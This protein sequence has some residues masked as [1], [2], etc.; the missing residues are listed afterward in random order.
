[1]D[2]VVVI[3]NPVASQFTG[4]A[5]RDVMAIFDKA[6]QVH[7]LWPGSGPEAEQAAAEAVADG[8]NIVVAMGGDGIVHHVAQ[9]VVGSE[10]V[11]GVIPVGTTNVFARILG[12]PTRPAKAAKLIARGNPPR[13]VGVARMVLSRGTVET[14]H[15]AL[16]SCGLG[17]DAEIVVSADA[18]PYRKYRFGSLHYASTALSVALRRFPRRRPHIEAVSEDRKAKAMTAI[19]QFREVYTYFGRRRIT[20]SPDRP[21]PMTLLVMTRLP[22]R[23]LPRIAFDALT[24]GDLRGVKGFEVWEGVEAAYFRADPAAPAQADGE[25]L[26]MAD[27]ASVEWVPDALKVASPYWSAR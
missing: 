3:A 8:A 4:G 21:S 6:A 15:Y 27:A 17:L 7:P 25:P 24:R 22:R 16:F 26:G 2:R 18:D 12:L 13:Q 11:L 5:H 9:G 23:R 19:F 14:S 10:A 1:M 20:I